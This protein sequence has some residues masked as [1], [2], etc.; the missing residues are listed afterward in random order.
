MNDKIMATY[1]QDNEFYAIRKGANGRY[2]IDY[3]IGYSTRIGRYY[4]EGGI[5]PFDTF[6]SALKAN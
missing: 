3:N 4:A 2:F 6:E 5:I 1:R